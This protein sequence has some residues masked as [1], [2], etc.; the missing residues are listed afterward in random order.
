MYISDTN[1]HEINHTWYG[2]LSC[3]SRTNRVNKYKCCVC[4]CSGANKHQVIRR[5]DV[6]TLY[7]LIKYTNHCIMPC[8]VFVYHCPWYSQHC[9]LCYI[10]NFHVRT[11]TEGFMFR[12][13]IIWNANH[14]KTRTILWRPTRLVSIPLTLTNLVSASAFVPTGAYLMLIFVVPW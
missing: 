12:P 10:C 13:T 9:W 8:I 6:E 11:A 5:H 14:A 3:R 2:R 7:Q 4:R 1:I